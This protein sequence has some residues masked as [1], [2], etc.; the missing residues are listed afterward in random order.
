MITQFSIKL[1]SGSPFYSILCKK[2]DFNRNTPLSIDLLSS[3]A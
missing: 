1:F 2:T 3:A